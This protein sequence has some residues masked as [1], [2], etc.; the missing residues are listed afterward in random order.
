MLASLNEADLVQQCT[1]G[2]RYAL[3]EAPRRYPLADDRVK[4]AKGYHEVGPHDR[5]VGARTLAEL[6]RLSFRSSR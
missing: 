1:P 4:V 6:E 5:G 2:G 3:L